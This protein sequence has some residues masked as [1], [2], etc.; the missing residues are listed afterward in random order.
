MRAFIETDIRKCRKVNNITGQVYGNLTVKSFA[1]K[2]CNRICY[3]NCE[4]S[5]GNNV[6]V[7]GG[8]LKR[9]R[10]CDKCG[11]KRQGET[12]TTHGMSRT[13]EYYIW[14]GARK[15]CSLE[16][17]KAFKNYGGRGITMC[18]EWFNSFDA[19]IRDMGPRPSSRHCIERLDNQLGYFKE[20]CV[21]AT[22]RTEARNKRS[23][24]N[25]TINGETR[26]IAEW[27]EKSGIRKD[28]LRRRVVVYGWTP[29]RAVNTPV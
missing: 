6:V 7:M 8:N 9:Q 1:G 21:W 5:C 26:C 22:Y 2:D 28:T 18:D 4:C 10:S 15:R 29:E 12:I 20:N 19:F 16:N 13:S 17:D 25:W 24:H 3:W 23:N 14:N 27:A 11:R